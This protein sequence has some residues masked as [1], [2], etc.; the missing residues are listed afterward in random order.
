MRPNR[1][2]RLE[3]PL[4]PY[5]NLH[6]PPFAS[7]RMSPKFITIDVVLSCLVCVSIPKH[8]KYSTYVDINLPRFPD[9]WLGSL[10]PSRSLSISDCIGDICGGGWWVSRT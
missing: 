1:D 6:P 5:Y 3:V 8:V 10:V 4:I 2:Y 9:F 7:P